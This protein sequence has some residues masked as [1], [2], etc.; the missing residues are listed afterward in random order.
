MRRVWERFSLSKKGDV[1]LSKLHCF[2]LVRGL[3]FGNAHPELL[4][5]GERKVKPITDDMNTK[6][7]QTEVIY[8][9]IFETE[10]CVPYLIRTRDLEKYVTHVF[11]YF[12]SWCETWSSATHTQNYLTTASG[13]PSPSRTR[14][15]RNSRS[16]ATSARARR[17]RPR[18][19]RS[20]SM[21]YSTRN[22]HYNG[23][24][25]GGY[26]FTAEL[27]L[28]I[29]VQDFQLIMNFMKKW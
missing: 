13:R 19:S 9:S 3:K 1:K 25:F 23:F 14:S 24:V 6:H 26:S 4:D 5:N 27:S 10:K 12:F 20:T 2:Q 22:R 18:R 15:G 28:K 21:I 17:R 29:P 7:R 8:I 16:A 11:L